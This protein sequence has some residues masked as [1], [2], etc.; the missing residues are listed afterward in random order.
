MYEY[1]L[2]KYLKAPL[3]QLIICNCIFCFIF[4]MYLHLKCCILFTLIL[5]LIDI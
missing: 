5:F 2:L 4:C 1:N 3:F